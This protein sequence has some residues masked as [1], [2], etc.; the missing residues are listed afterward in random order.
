MHRSSRRSRHSTCRHSRC[1]ISDRRRRPGCS[2]CVCIN[3]GHRGCI[4]SKPRR[5]R[6]ALTPRC[7]RHTVMY[8]VQR[9]SRRRLMHCMCWHRLSRCSIRH[10][11][12]RHGGCTRRHRHDRR[13]R[14]MRTRSHSVHRHRRCIHR[15][16]K[17][18]CRLR[19]CMLG[20]HRLQRPRQG[21]HSLSRRYWY[22]VSGVHR[23]HRHTGT[24]GWLCTHRLTTGRHPTMRKDRRC[25]R[26]WWQAHRQPKAKVNWS[27][28][29]RKGK[30][31]GRECSG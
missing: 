6:R 9:H 18:S 13:S 26:T 16:S 11:V 2:R 5:S 1:T 21:R 31:G 27:M 20:A 8:R 23:G 4:H 3:S 17:S 15:P 24:I 29:G 22:A 30:E 7:S 14:S 25:H 19:S 12:H 28:G 10:K